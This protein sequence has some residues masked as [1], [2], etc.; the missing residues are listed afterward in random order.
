MTRS[1]PAVMITAI[2][3]GEQLAFD[4]NQENTHE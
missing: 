1:V 4:N 3:K 2:F